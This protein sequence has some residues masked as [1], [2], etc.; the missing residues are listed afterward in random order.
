[1]S[2]VDTLH[3]TYAPIMRFSAGENFFP[4][5]VDDFLGYSA[6]YRKGENKPLVQQGHLNAA[7]LQ[8]TQ[9]ADQVFLRSVTTGPLWGKDVASEWNRD[10]LHLLRE[11]ML[12]PR[13]TW[14]ETTAKQAYQWLSAKTEPA[15]RRFWWNDLLLPK[16]EEDIARGSRSQ[17]PR[18]ILPSEVRNSA[19]ERYRASQGER[20]RFTYYFREVQ[21]GG[22]LNLQ[23]WFYYA[24]NDW[25]NGFGGFNDHEGD[26][27]GFHLFF[28]LDGGRPVEPPAYACYLGH[29]S[30]IT[31]PWGH[32]DMEIIG[33]HPVINVAAGSHASY[34]ERK[35][36]PLMALYNL[37]D[38]ATGDA[39]ELDNAD[40][41]NRLP[42]EQQPWV[43][44]VNVSWGTRYWLPLTLLNLAMRT[45]G[46]ILPREM[47]LPGVSAP[48]G[49]HF[50]DRGD[51]REVWRAP[52][53]FASITPLPAN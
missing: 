37:I 46:V 36:Y 35:E 27:E 49:P 40:W 47:L 15:A 42:L 31:K 41:S 6:L 9:Q 1:M 26:W 20:P 7:M 4:M 18:F 45:V 17:L 13:Q 34:P 21:Q 28:K 3:H 39:Y 12:K 48:R 30:R 32:P 51:E 14:N 52:L 33:T 38:Y 11:Y 22:Y 53:Q 43:N 2:V 10:A 44:Q 25:A 23:Y 50:D 24:Y 29:H 8:K 16:V 5:A 19:I